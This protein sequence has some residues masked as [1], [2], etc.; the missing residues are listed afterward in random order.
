MEVPAI[1]APPLVNDGIGYANTFAHWVEEHVHDVSGFATE[2]DASP[3]H[4]VP[5]PPPPTFPC[6]VMAHTE[7]AVPVVIVSHPPVPVTNV[8]LY[9]IRLDPCPIA[10]N[11]LIP[12]AFVPITVR[13]VPPCSDTAPD[14]ALEDKP[15]PGLPNLR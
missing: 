11:P 3:V 14:P 7:L 1:V 2:V 8:G 9:R 13:P 6:T 15:V 5:L 4:T 12:G 10:H